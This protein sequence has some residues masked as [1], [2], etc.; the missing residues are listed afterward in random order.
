M[1]D[2]TLSVKSL[3][4]EQAP[5]GDSRV[6]SKANAMNRQ[7]SGEEGVRRGSPASHSLRSR[8]HDALTPTRSLAEF[9][10]DLA[11]SLLAGNQV[12][13]IASRAC[14]EICTQFFL[15]KKTVAFPVTLPLHHDQ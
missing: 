12:A 5:V 10:S 8:S 9:F 4:C 1:F 11:G 14:G 7:R 15:K 13:G 2:G 6:Q 3:A